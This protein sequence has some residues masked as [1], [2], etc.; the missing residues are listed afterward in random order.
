MKNLKNKIII[1][2]AAL[3]FVFVA[4][5]E[6][7]NL[8]LGIRYMPT[9]STFKMQTS[10]GE[11]VKGIVNLGW[12]VSGVVGFNFGEHIGIQGEVIYSS[13]SRKYDETV[14]DVNFERKIKLTYLNVPLLFVVNTGKHKIVNVNIVVGPQIGILVG[15]HVYTTPNGTSISEAVLSVKKGDVGLAYGVGI[16][17]G[18][19]KSR[20]LRLGAGFRGVY[21]LLDVTNN[22]TAAADSYYV[23]DG[24]HVH[25]Y[26]AYIGLSILI[27]KQKE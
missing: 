6:A 19:N 24:T 4:K 17:F 25:T 3:L 2:L 12:G 11:T 14:F 13:V 16:D 27:G 9:F 7:Q 18:L 22:Q 8:E 5:T 26:A 21:G 10:T 1:S 23:L 15:K 20:S